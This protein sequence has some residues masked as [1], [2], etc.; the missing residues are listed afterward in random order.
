M[1]TQRLLSILDHLVLATPDLQHSI[2]EIRAL[3]GV[4][5]APGGKHPRWRT[6]NALLSLGPRLY[7]ELMGPDE[8][9]PDPVHPR[10]FG[11]DVLRSHRLA[12][13]V[14]RSA[15][16]QRMCSDAQAAGIALG[17]IQAGSRRRPDGTLLEWRMTDLMADR[18]GGAVPYF[19]D[20]GT[21]SHPAARAP[22]G[23]TL[24]DLQVFH[25]EPGKVT[26]LLKKL[27]IN[28]NVEPGA[29][30]LAAQIRTPKGVV[31]LRQVEDE[32][33]RS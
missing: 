12:T 11:I 10:P 6:Q 29:M 23:C 33:K 5:P 21:S 18:C 9:P 13:W 17:E 2:E 15:D 31:W 7:L 28:L 26:A 3:L 25:P 27:G 1:I 8:S 22:A 32:G 4:S 30:T 19:I 16:L 14:L 20:W 24:E